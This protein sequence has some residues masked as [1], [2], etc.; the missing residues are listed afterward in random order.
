MDSKTIR[1]ARGHLEG[2]TE[3][4]D[5]YFGGRMTEHDDRYELRLSA[6]KSE[7][8]SYIV[9]VTLENYDKTTEGREQMLNAV[10]ELKVHC[11]VYFGDYIL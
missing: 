5:T 6:F 9:G 1:E 11:E 4:T 3:G 2:L 10:R 7:D 8:N